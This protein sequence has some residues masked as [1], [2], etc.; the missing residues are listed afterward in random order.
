[1][2]QDPADVEAFFE[3]HPDA[4]AVYRSVRSMA[5]AIGS[6]DVRVTRSQVAFRRRRGFAYLWLPGRWL[7]KPAAEVVLSIAL[8]R[9]D[10]S[11]RFK[12][13]VQPARD[14]WMHHLEVRASDEI[15]D[16]VRAWL[17]EAFEHAA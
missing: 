9:R 1:M 2:A 3:G 11:P 5:E 12:P 7:A 10:E 17:E 4:L 16:E 6:I 14:V 13:V 15:D 8:G